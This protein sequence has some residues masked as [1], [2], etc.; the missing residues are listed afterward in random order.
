MGK[1][2]RTYLT[3]STGT[4]NGLGET[5]F[6]L[7]THSIHLR[8]S[9]SPEL[10]QRETVLAR[11]LLLFDRISP[12]LRQRHTFSLET[13]VSNSTVNTSL[14]LS[15]ITFSFLLPGWGRK[16]P[17]HQPRSYFTPP[18]SPTPLHWQQALPEHVRKPGNN[19]LDSGSWSCFRKLSRHA[20]GSGSYNGSFNRLL[21]DFL[22]H[23]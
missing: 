2:S 19:L 10:C 11:Y 20:V 15:S 8:N 22:D 21:M 4:V 1:V 14:G 6:R 12:A 7:I 3:S 18:A 13:S 23:D 9:L 5:Q 17:V 16:S